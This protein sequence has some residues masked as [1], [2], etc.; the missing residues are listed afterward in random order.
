VAYRRVG[1]TAYG[2]SGRRS[3]SATER[4]MAALHKVRHSRQEEFCNKQRCGAALRR[5]GGPRP[6]LRIDSKYLFG[7]EPPPSGQRST[8]RS[9][10]PTLVVVV[11]CRLS[12]GFAFQKE[13]SRILLARRPGRSL[14]RQLLSLAIDPY[15]QKFLLLSP[16][17]PAQAKFR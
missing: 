10:L 5:T 1:V 13:P 12:L 6:V 3:A 4:S 17:L 11:K 16:A 8:V 14:D 15:R 7:V 2:R 9:R